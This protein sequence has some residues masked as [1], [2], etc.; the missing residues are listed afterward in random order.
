MEI[1]ALW[2]HRIAEVLYYIDPI[3]MGYA[4]CGWIFLYS[5]TSAYQRKIAMRCY[6]LERQ[7]DLLLMHYTIDKREIEM[8][9]RLRKMHE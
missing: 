5:R 9:E 3:L 1:I 2:F 4:C 8:I 6:A 7:I